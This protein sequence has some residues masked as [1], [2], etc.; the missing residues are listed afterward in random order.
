MP[1]TESE[2]HPSRWSRVHKGLALTVY[3]AAVDG[4]FGWSVSA[5]SS[6]THLVGGD[7]TSFSLAIVAAETEARRRA[8]EYLQEG[9]S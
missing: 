3:T 9:G 5:P 4:W 7:E 1:K 2:W 6:G 8:P